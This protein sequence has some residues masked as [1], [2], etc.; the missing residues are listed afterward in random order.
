MNTEIPGSV[1][2]DLLVFPRGWYKHY[3]VNVGNGEIV[4]V[5]STEGLTSSSSSAEIAWKISSAISKIASIKKQKF[6]DIPP[7]ARIFYKE[8]DG[9]PLPA[10]EIV[11]RA[12]EFYEQGHFEY[13]LL[14]RNCEHF[15]RYCCYDKWESKLVEEMKDRFIYYLL[16]AV[17]F[18][19]FLLKLR[20]N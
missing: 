15:A 20:Q 4:H 1:A 9:E 18:S 3:A 5:T 12:L 6:S 16:L 8:N 7:R 10:E 19:A 11:K 17:L 2:G 14:T 13:N